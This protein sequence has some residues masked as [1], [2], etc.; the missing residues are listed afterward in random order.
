ML[1]SGAS[2]LLC[3]EIPAG[4]EGQNVGR[5]SKEYALEIE[6]QRVREPERKNSDSLALCPSD[7]L[8][9]FLLHIINQPS[10]LLP[11]QR[12]CSGDLVGDVFRAFSGMYLAVKIRNI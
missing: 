9:R 4:N 12:S 2:P 7:S 1:R 10:D 3:M 11:D 8:F 5:D 6:S